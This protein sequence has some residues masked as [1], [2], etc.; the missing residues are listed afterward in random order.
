MTHSLTLRDAFQ[1][2][3]ARRA[4]LQREIELR[5]AEI[6]TLDAEVAGVQEALGAARE[7]TPP[8]PAPR[9]IRLRPT[10]VPD[11]VCDRCGKPFKRRAGSA[12]RF[13][14][15]ECYGAGDTKI[16]TRRARILEALKGGPLMLHELRNDPS[17]RLANATSLYNDLRVL[18]TTGKVTRCEGGYRLGGPDPDQADVPTGEVPDSADVP[19]APAP[20]R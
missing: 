4:Q 17:L 5:Q 1:A 8:T 3:R 18:E 12:G 16:E 20:P 15:R 14:S 9:P 13:C 10:P 6:E 19:F 2:N 7:A 11:S